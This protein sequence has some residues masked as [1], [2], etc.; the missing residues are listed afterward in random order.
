MGML[1]SSMAATPAVTAAA[2]ETP[3]KPTSP[4]QSIPEITEAVKLFN[5]Q[6]Y[7]GAYEML[8][9]ALKDHKELP[10]AED[11]MAQ[12]FFRMAQVA[13]QNNQNQ[14]E[15][16]RSMRNWLEMGIQKN[17]TDPEAYLILGELAVLDNRVAEA[18]LLYNKCSEL[19][20]GF[21]GDNK[22]KENMEP[23]ILSGQ[24][25]IAEA[26]EAWPQA[27]KLLEEWLKKAPKNDTIMLRLAQVLFQQSKASDAY[28]L[29]K[30]AKEANK[31]Q[32]YPDARLALF[33]EAFP[34]QH[35]ENHNNAIKWMEKALKEAP[36]DDITTRLVAAQ[37]ALETEQIDKAKEWS[38][39][40]M[41]LAD[42]L[43]QND[44]SVDAKL[45]RGVVALFQKDYLGA[46][47]YFQSALLM[48][49]GNFSASNNYAL[50]LM[51]QSKDKEKVKLALDYAK[52]NYA[53]NSRNAEA[54][55][56][57]GWAL[58]KNEM[59]ADAERA[60]RLALSGT[61]VSP[62]TLYYLAAVL[63]DSKT[64]PKEDDAKK[65]EENLKKRQE[66]ATAALKIALDS[67]RPFTMKP[68]AT[69]LY[70]KLGGKETATGT[71]PSAKPTGT[72]SVTPSVTGSGTPTGTKKATGKP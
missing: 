8:Q 46:D 16:V 54:A 24:A 2:P 52:N 65:S 41:K 58:Y 28:D 13:A 49:P 38:S 21:K 10:P 36:K 64:N 29:L 55:S 5:N 6:N 30:Q 70:A 45:L 18:E 26:R 63:A 60:L 15:Y 56:T 66:E 37:W 51:E 22:R 48:A 50:A 43:K 61:S 40:A 12:F 67:K 62:D 47:M 59:Y 3:E 68:E 39:D 11:M 17:S 19:M 34:K 44:K 33:Y 20:A 1:T 35:D 23:R 9:K 72:G 42:T 7:A 31:E 69:T 71:T 27:Q 4:D 32:L 53:T 25:T 57:F 14:T